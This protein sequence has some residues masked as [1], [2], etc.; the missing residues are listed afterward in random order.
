MPIISRYPCVPDVNVLAQTLAMMAK[1]KK[2]GLPS[3]D[4]D[5]AEATTRMALEGVVVR[6][7][8]QLI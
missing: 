7:W 5:S 8:L 1:R 4:F 3:G 6:D 2:G